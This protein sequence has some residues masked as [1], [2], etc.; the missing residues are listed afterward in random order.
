MTLTVISPASLTS[1]QHSSPYA[2][3][4]FFDN[5]RAGIAEGSLVL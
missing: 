5:A 4:L 3:Q 2:A 1:V